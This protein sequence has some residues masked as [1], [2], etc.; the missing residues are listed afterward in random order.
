MS[1]RRHEPGLNPA[2]VTFPP[3]PPVEIAAARLQTPT[4][5]GSLHVP[6]PESVSPNAAFLIDTRGYACKQ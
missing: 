5:V 3:S 2:G 4:F 6:V 1:Q